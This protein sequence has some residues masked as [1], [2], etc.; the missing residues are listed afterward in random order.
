MFSNMSM[1]QS[2]FIYYRGINKMPLTYFLNKELHAIRILWSTLIYKEKS[3]D[4]SFTDWPDTDTELS[5]HSPRPLELDR[6]NFT[7]KNIDFQIS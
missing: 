1:T 2:A 4:Y 5:M 7:L 6:Q 3:S